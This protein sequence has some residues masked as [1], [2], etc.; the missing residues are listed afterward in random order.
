MDAPFVVKIVS[1]RKDVGKTLFAERLVRELS[2][3]GVKVASLKHIHHGRLDIDSGKDTERMFLAGSSISI[4]Y[5]GD[6][7]MVLMRGASLDYLLRLVNDARPDV[8]VVEGFKDMRPEGF[9]V[10]IASRGDVGSCDPS[11]VDLATSMEPGIVEELKSRG[12]NALRF[13]EAVSY[14]LSLALAIR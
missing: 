13:D 9:T 3:R 12:C 2:E 5:A 11:S 6:T 14:V 4:G 1:S 8:I 7:S 10:Y